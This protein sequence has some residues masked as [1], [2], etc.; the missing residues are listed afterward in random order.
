MRD[1]LRASV[2]E[3][4]SSRNLHLYL[5]MSF[6]RYRNRVL[7]GLEAG[8]AAGIGAIGFSADM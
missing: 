7:A 5:I 4:C 6:I 1:A 3:V 8:E 2:L